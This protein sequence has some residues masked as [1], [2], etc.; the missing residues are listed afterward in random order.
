[1]PP[2]LSS[3]GPITDWMSGVMFGPA[4]GKYAAVDK[5]TGAVKVSRAALEQLQQP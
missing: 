5:A 2:F 1:M 4:I 3:M